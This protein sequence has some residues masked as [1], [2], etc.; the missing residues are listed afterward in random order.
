MSGRQARAA[1][2]AKYSLPA[3]WA[4]RVLNR[5]RRR[6]ELRR[7][8]VRRLAKLPARGQYRVVL[9]PRVFWVECHPGRVV[10]L[11]RR[12]VTILLRPCRES[13]PTR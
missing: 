10:M 9:G 12:P 8:D 1:R 2:A 7:R 5:T 11:G 13:S 4:R 3:Q 6:L